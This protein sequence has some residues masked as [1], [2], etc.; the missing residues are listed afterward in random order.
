MFTF[1]YWCMYFFKCIYI[2]IYLSY[3][4]IYL[5]LWLPNLMLAGA[6]PFPISGWM[7][8]Y[9]LRVLFPCCVLCEEKRNEKAFRRKAKKRRVKASYSLASFAYPEKFNSTKSTQ[10]IYER[11]ITHILILYFSLCFS[12]EKGGYCNSSLVEIR[13]PFTHLVHKTD[14]P[15]SWDCLFISY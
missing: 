4:N 2:F 12:L 7:Q 5:V 9:S 13:K 6:F 10:C 3:V 1:I 8:L 14:I 11:K 15:C